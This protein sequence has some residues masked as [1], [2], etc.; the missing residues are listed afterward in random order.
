M[1]VPKYNAIDFISS[2]SIIRAVPNNSL[3]TVQIMPVPYNARKI[4]IKEINYYC[5]NTTV[6]GVMAL[7]IPNLNLNI[8][9]HIGNGNGSTVIERD[10]LL[11]SSLSNSLTFQVVIYRVDNNGNLIIDNGNNLPVYGS[12]VLS[13]SGIISF[14]IDIYRDQDSKNIS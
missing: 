4:K 7:I 1:S 11:T 12:G 10:L 5:P 8:P 14:T 6:N 13:A 3:M 9:F 2:Q